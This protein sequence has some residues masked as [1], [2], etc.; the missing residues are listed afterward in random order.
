MCVY[1]WSAFWLLIP[2]IKV[3]VYVIMCQTVTAENREKD[4]MGV[5]HVRQ[6]GVGGKEQGKTTQNQV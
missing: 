6:G 1:S 3:G 4:K 2:W 5:K